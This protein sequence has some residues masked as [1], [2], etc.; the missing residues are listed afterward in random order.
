MAERERWEGRIRAVENG[1]EAAI[2]IAVAVGS[3]AKL[4]Q[5][6]YKALR[7]VIVRD[8]ER[9]ERE[10]YAPQRPGP[11]EGEGQTCCRGIITEEKCHG[12]SRQDHKGTML[13]DWSTSW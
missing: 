5:D 2:A 13:T 3:D 10:G 7:T 4:V 1:G 12:D 6:R 8:R 9:G 11:R